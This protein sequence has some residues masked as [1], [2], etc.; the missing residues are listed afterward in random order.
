MF[1][2][3][4]GSM[5]ELST[6]EDFRFVAGVEIF[7]LLDFGVTIISS[8]SKELVI[9]PVAAFGRCVAFRFIA[10]VFEILDSLVSRTSDS[11][12]VVSGFLL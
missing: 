11:R 12:I 10:S 8:M 2:S 1:S 4:L 9:V 3:N 7:W 6:M 5:S